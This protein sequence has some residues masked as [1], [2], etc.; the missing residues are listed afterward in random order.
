MQII[1]ILV[2][3]VQNMEQMILTFNLSNMI[4]EVRGVIN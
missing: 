2:Q 1:Q 4:T 3:I